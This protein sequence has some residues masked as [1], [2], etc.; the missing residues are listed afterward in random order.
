MTR[1]TEIRIISGSY[2]GRTGTA[3]AKVFQKSVDFPDEPAHGFH[4]TLDDGAW[5]TVRWDH[6][7][8]LG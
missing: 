4:V 3:E 5:V 7:R 1:C 2:R 8:V 6:A